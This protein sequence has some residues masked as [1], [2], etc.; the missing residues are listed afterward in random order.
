MIKTSTGKKWWEIF[1]F[2]KFNDGETQPFRV[3]GGNASHFWGKI[4]SK[5]SNSKFQN[6]VKTVFCYDFYN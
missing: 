4:F 3:T 1:D 5:N 2:G 6:M